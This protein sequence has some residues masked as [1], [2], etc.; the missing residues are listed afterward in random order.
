MEGK[1][2]F[3]DTLVDYSLAAIAGGMVLAVTGILLIFAL[4]TVSGPLSAPGSRM[5]AALGAVAGVSIYL[6]VNLRKGNRQLDTGNEIIAAFL[7]LLI[8]PLLGLLS[9]L[10]LKYLG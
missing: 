3:G 7:P 5:I 6:I 4:P 1:A 8:T 9:G 10:A 2:D